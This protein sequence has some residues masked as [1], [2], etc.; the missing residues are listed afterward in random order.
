MG[1][2]LGNFMG[3][4][5]HIIATGIKEV[6]GQISDGNWWVVDFIG[7]SETYGRI[8]IP[9]SIPTFRQQIMA[10]LKT[11]CEGDY[12]AYHSYVMFYNKDDALLAYLKYR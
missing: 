4:S 5:H 9:F 2:T 10:E 6:V 8:E 12:Q 3:L 7:D 1:E 11:V